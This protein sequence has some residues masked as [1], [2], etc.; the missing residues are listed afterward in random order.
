MAEDPTF[1]I[2]LVLAG[3]I[4][5][6]AY[7]AGVI[8]FLLQALDAWEDAKQADRDVPR[9]SVKL[10]AVSGASGGAIT[11]ALL[12]RALAGGIEP[13][14]DPTAP[15]DQPVPDPM[16]RPA[17]APFRNTLYATWV[18]SIDIRHLLKLKDLEPTRA[19]V[20]SLLD[21]TVLDYIGEN[22]L[23][24]SAPRAALPR[25]VA[26]PLH[27]FFTTSN[28]RG[29]PY[30]L[31][32]S[33]QIEGYEHMMTAYADHRRFAL[34]GTA[35][36]D[37]LMLDPKTVGPAGAWA[38]MLNAAL[39][40]GAFPVGLAPRLLSRLSADY[41]KR[42]WPV[43]QANPLR[44][45]SD[46][47]GAAVP[48]GDLPAQQKIVCGDRGD[49]LIAV[50]ER[51][52][53]VQPLWP[54]GIDQETYTYKY[55]NVDGG[56]FNNQPLELARRVL[57]GGVGHNPRE[58]DKA[59]RALIMIEPFPTQSGVSPAY[60]DT[61]IGL[62]NVVV[63]MFAALKEQARFKLEDLLLAQDEQVFS[64]FVVAPV[65]S[66]AQ[67]HA[68]KPAI[69]ADLLGGFGAFF[70]EAFRHHDF[71]LGRRNCQQFL[72]SHFALPEDNPLF[73][74]Q[75]AD[76]LSRY[77]VRD[78]R[79]DARGK[80]QLQIIPVVGDADVD[81]PLPRR[82]R[83]SDV[84]LGALRAMITTR[85]EAVVPRLIDEV[86]IA[87]M[88]TG[89]KTLWQGAWLFGQRHKLADKIMEKIESELQRLA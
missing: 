9:H 53:A 74:S 28:L 39:A 89:L 30:G 58:G 54:P 60:D 59:V 37:A 10:R 62:V 45:A 65:Y 35:P 57:T 22:A 6:G 18:R 66:D 21:S 46:P 80:R 25:Y 49:P 33:G 34:G 86:P 20:K 75:P 55:W 76:R 1:E 4:S 2:G 7:S 40:S 56:L 42:E 88:K 47:D 84:D 79:P 44:R 24:V 14:K 26:D 61:G 13:V 83:P 78:G 82:P 52:A 77:A 11:S 19:R 50:A 16:A 85:L 71:Q 64:R 68:T 5:A 67:G 15:P 31:K 29:V 73:A 63:G 87:L 81:V 51:L 70:A 3:T 36:A 23:A 38:T 43:P 41:L 8:D 48:E 17:P 32:F 27:L 72:R 69:A 12:A